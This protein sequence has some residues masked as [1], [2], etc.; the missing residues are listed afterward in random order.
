M[1][2]ELFALRLAQKLGDGAAAQHYATLLGQYSEGLLLVAYRRTIRS[3]QHADLG[4]RFH[5]EL[6]HARPNG[7]NGNGA[8]L[9]AVRIERRSVA[10]AVFHGD[11]LEYTQVR[12]LSSVK[13]KALASAVGFIN[14]MSSCFALDSAVIE[15]VEI[16]EEYQRRKLHEAINVVL[17][18]RALP[19]WAIS[20]KDLF[21][22]YGQPALKSR[23]ELREVVSSMW[24][25]LAGAH[26]QVFIQ[27]AVALGLYVQTERHFIIN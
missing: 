25:V 9:I 15:A 4:R 20:K 17:R 3:G 16:G 26:A 10:A 22:A 6:K 11:Q 7:S 12:Q 21:A 19:I 24:P 2:S 18:E 5:V 27:D 13:E 1:P 14:W 23:M 8:R